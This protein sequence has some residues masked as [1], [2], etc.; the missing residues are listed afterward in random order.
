[1]RQGKTLAMVLRYAH[2]S[3]AHIDRAMEALDRTM[4]EPSAEKE[5]AAST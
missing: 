3:G 2:V 4:P 1:M 5:N